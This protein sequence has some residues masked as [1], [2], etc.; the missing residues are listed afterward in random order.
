MESAAFRLGFPRGAARRAIYSNDDD[1]LRAVPC[2][3]YN[4]PIAYADLI[5]NG[6]TGR[7]LKAVTGYK[8]DKAMN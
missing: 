2:L 7:Y 3:I 1:T 8:M 5:L 4:G 6:D